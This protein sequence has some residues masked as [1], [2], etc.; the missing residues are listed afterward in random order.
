MAALTGLYISQS[1]GGVIHL[2][3]NAG[4]SGTTPTQ[5][6]DGIGNNMGVW[7]NGAGNVSASSFTG[8][9]S[10][11]TSASY[12][13]TATS[14]SYSLVATSASYSLTATSASYSLIATSASYALFATTA[15]YALVAANSIL[16]NGTA[17]SVFAKTG[18][19]TFVGNQTISGSVSNA[20]K[21]LTISSDTASIDLSSGNLFTLTL[22]NTTNTHISASNLQKGQ[23]V[24]LQVTNG[25]LGNAT[26]TFSSV[27]TFPSGSSYIPFASSSAV[28]SI[29]F[30]SYDG[31]KLRGVAQ[32]NFI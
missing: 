13:N 16:L 21:A 18:S 8:L 20:V 6:Q 4:I 7:F 25:S 31:N 17:S 3:T 9:A 14:A 29:S 1:Y 27:F 22:V 30:I 11:A 15:S 2:S 19:N 10:N 32:N 24:S 23:T 5:L 28:D 12:A 26:V